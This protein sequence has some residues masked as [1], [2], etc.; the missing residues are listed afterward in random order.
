MQS[1]GD[2]RGLLKLII[3]KTIHSKVKF[4]EKVDKSFLF[5]MT[6]LLVF[7]AVVTAV[8][9]PSLWGLFDYSI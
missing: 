1:Q 5:A 7:V 3:V 6:L 8:Y 9:L 4:S 2:S